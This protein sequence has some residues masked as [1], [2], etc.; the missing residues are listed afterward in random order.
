MTDIKK[1]QGKGGVKA[2]KLQLHKETLKDLSVKKGDS[3]K[4]GALRVNSSGKSC[5]IECE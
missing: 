2:K 3:P 4:G 5:R 1:K